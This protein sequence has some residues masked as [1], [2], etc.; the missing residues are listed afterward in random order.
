MKIKLSALSLFFTFCYATSAYS[1]ISGP[2]FRSVPQQPKIPKIEMKYGKAK[3][4]QENTE[5][6]QSQTAVSEEEG[7]VV[8]NSSPKLQL[9]YNC[10]EDNDI[11]FCVDAD[12]KPVDGKI[13][14]YDDLGTTISIENFKNGYLNGLCSYF[15]PDGNPK[16]RLYYKDGKK[17]GMY[18]YYY[19]ERNIKISANYKNGLLDGQ[20][21]VYLPNNSL[22]GRMKYRRGYL[23]KGYCKENGKKVDFSKDFLKSYPLNVINTCGLSK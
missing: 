19:P 3:T 7:Y 15:Y 20:L 11:K 21:D 23:E 12:N 10:Q 18:K 14:Q 1:G 4:V 2:G 13:A 5:I 16:E 17:N 9:Q 6:V 22:H 8:K